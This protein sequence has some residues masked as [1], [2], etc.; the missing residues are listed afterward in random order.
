MYH[1]R[2]I[3]SYKGS[4]FFGWQDLGASTA[5]P[6][7]QREV[8]QVLKKICNYQNCI[9]AGASRTDAG[10]H[11]QGQV[12]KFTLP[13]EIESEKLQQGMNSLLPKE[14]RIL[15]CEPSCS[16]FNPNLDSISKK[17]HYYFC[18]D[19]IFNPVLNDIVVHFVATKKNDPAA[20]IDIIA[21]KQASKLFIGEQDFY[22]FAARGTNTGST[23]RTVFDCQI[24]GAEFPGFSNAIYCLQIQ[25]DGFLKQMVRYIVGALFEVGRGTVDMQQIRDALATRQEKKL[26]PKAKPHGL[27]LMEIIYQTVE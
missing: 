4:N 16:K 6:T 18:T 21:M 10:V 5:K 15:D 8:H 11:A 17:Y 14:I 3:V 24:V 25:G 12:A 20:L 22:G 1:H 7:V 27:H 19:R 13:I 26:S 9:V 2:A 23:V